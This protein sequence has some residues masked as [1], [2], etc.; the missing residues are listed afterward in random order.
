MFSW[1]ARAYNW[2]AG[3]IDSVTAGWVHDLI[4]GLYSFLHVIFGGVISEWNKL[5]GAAKSFADNFR[6]FASAVANA[7]HYLWHVY[8]PEFLRYLDNEIVAPLKTAYQ[9]VINEGRVVWHYIQNPDD[10]VEL[11]WDS[12]LKKLETSAWDTGEKLGSFFLSLILRNLDKVLTLAEDILD[13]VF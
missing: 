8:W 6:E 3:K 5:Y 10:L 11:I 1:I 4:N 9:W 7:W 13:A 2:A 12:I